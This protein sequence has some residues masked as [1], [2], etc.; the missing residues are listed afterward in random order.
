MKLLKEKS[1]WNV[2]KWELK[3]DDDPDKTLW[4]D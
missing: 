1:P 2:K 3:T 4:E